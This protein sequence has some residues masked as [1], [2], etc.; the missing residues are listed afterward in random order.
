[1][2][3][4][5]I[6]L[7][8]PSRT[9]RPYTTPSNCRRRTI[10]VGFSDLINTFGHYNTA[11]AAKTTI[12]NIIMYAHTITYAHAHVHVHA[13]TRTR[14]AY[15]NRSAIRVRVCVV[16]AAPPGRPRLCVWAISLSVSI[17][18]ARCVHSSPSAAAAEER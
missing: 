16:H 4:N 15:I 18:L 14:T 6:I 11:G 12:Y 7:N 3:Y 2:Y 10:C 13:R 8:S 1:M 17:S 9:F 5:I